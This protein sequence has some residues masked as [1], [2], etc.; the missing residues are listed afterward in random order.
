MFLSVELL[1]EIIGGDVH[2]KGFLHSNRS[3]SVRRYYIIY[4]PED[5]MMAKANECLDHDWDDAYHFNNK[6]NIIHTSYCLRC[7]VPSNFTIGAIAIFR[8]DTRIHIYDQIP[9]VL[10]SSGED[11]PTLVSKGSGIS[12][13]LGEPYSIEAIRIFIRGLI[14]I[15]KL[16]TSYFKTT[17]AVQSDSS[18]ASE[19][20]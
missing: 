3:M 2:L 6:M 1:E 7:G 10:P 20:Q 9:K 4:K 18:S 17:E 8:N 14:D 16:R 11:R 15:F 12:I 19:G 5:S 13:E